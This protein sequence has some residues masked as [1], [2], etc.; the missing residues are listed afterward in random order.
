MIIVTV[1]LVQVASICHQL[2]CK[3]WKFQASHSRWQIKQFPQLCV[4]PYIKS[5]LCFIYLHVLLLYTWNS[6]SSQCF[7]TLSASKLLVGWVT[8]R[9]STVW[10]T[11]FSTSY[12][13]TLS[14]QARD[15][16]WS[17]RGKDT[18]KEVKVVIVM[19]VV[20]VLVVV[21]G[22]VVM[23]LV[24]VV[25]AVVLVEVVVVAVA[26]AMTAAV[27]VVVMVVVLSWL[28][29]WHITGNQNI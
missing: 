26:V 16:I 17:S 3:Q 12:A 18:F 22:V 28:H 13:Q 5:G 23:V 24:L 27:V 15:Q 25:V 20:V 21:V 29:M 14:F 10:E 2:I 6:I 11:C 8:G 4:D 9:A 1:H 7:D 19:I